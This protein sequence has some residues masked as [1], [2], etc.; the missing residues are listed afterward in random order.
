MTKQTKLSPQGRGRI[1]NLKKRRT[2]TRHKNG[3]TGRVN[4]TRDAPT[5]ERDNDYTTF[6]T[7]THV[8]RSSSKTHAAP[9][10]TEPHK[11]PNGLQ[12][13]FLR[14]AVFANWNASAPAMELCRPPTSVAPGLGTYT[15]HYQKKLPRTHT[16]TGS[17]SPARGAR[18]A[19]R[20]LSYGPMRPASSFSSGGSAS[21]PV[22]GRSAYDIVIAASQ[23]SQ[24][25]GCLRT[26]NRQRQ[27]R[28]AT[29]LPA[30]P[31]RTGGTG[32]R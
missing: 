16:H 31:T 6:P 1:S 15:G 21:F 10:T 29:W 20:E 2:R 7:W 30:P 8:Y 18:G 4:K 5:R 14:P 32:W 17:A 23:G 11:V 27:G 12:V 3:S 22:R 13:F 26:A 9:R 24:R 19:P 28:C 25:P